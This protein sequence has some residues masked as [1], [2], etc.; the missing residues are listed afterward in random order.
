MVAAI[1]ANDMLD[2]PLPP[3]RIRIV[4]SDPQFAPSVE[5]FSVPYT[6]GGLAGATALLEVT[7]PHYAGGPLFKRFLNEAELA[8]GVHTLDW[9]GKCNTRPATWRE[10][11]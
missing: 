1:D 5:S 2:L 7:S 8:D 10:S 4:R 3:I 9:D 6:T 11:S